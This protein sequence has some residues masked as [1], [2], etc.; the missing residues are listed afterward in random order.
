VPYHP[1]L[2]EYQRDRQ[3]TRES[4]ARA[5]ATLRK[6]NDPC[7]PEKIGLNRDRRQ[8]DW[9]HSRIRGE[10]QQSGRDELTPLTPDFAEF[11]LQTPEGERRGRVFRLNQDGGSIPLD[12]HHVGQ[13]V[14]KIGDKARVIVNAVDEMADSL[15][16]NHPATPGE[17]A[18]PSNNSSNI[19]PKST[20]AG[21]TDD[22]VTPIAETVC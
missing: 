21:G 14:A 6:E 4:Q 11:L 17:I 19:Y 9:K 20:E 15:W 16:A 12:V 13:I 10:S 3:F 22:T 5:I 2:K 18:V 7:Q 8:R 1:R